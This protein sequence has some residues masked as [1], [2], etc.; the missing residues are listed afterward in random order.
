VEGSRVNLAYWP[1]V[2]Q[3][4]GMLRVLGV[5]GVLCVRCGGGGDDVGMWQ[6]LGV[7]VRGAHH[8]GVPRPDDLPRE[9]QTHNDKVG[10]LVQAFSH[11]RSCL[12]SG[13]WQQDMHDKQANRQAAISKQEGCSTHFH[14]FAEVEFGGAHADG[15]HCGSD[16]QG[17]AGGGVAIVTA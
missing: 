5:L 9:L 3:V 8:R 10:K 11:K 1:C 6:K 12:S 4:E 17:G 16:Q 15:I 14:V 7:G 13:R 2:V